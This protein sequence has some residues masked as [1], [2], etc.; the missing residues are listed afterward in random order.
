MRFILWTFGLL[1]FSLGQYFLTGIP[2]YAIFIP[3]FLISIF[4]ILVKRFK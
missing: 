3:L 1:I 4:S 2:G